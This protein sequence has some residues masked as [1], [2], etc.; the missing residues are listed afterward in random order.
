MV[1]IILNL[2][3]LKISAHLNIQ[4]LREDHDKELNS[5]KD[6]GTTETIEELDK[7]CQMTEDKEGDVTKIGDEWDMLMEQLKAL[8]QIFNEERVK[9]DKYD[10]TIQ[11]L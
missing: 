1:K 11:V 7:L 10:E 3:T 4:W 9:A 6:K 8:Q 2:A 5:A